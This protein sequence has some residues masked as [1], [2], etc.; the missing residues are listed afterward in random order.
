MITRDRSGDCQVYTSQMAG[1]ND[2]TARH[3]L[4]LL[5]HDKIG[6]H[7]LLAYDETK[8]ILAVCGYLG[9]CV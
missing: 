9:V 5:K 6:E 1:L 7:F 8:R 3:P 4:K 2:A